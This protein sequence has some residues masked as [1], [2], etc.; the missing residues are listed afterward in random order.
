MNVGTASVFGAAL[1]GVADPE[2]ESGSDFDDV[3]VG[4]RSKKQLDFNPGDPVQTMTNISWSFHEELSPPDDL[5]THEDDDGF[6]HDELRIHPNIA[7]HFDKPMSSFL[8]MIPLDFW[9]N[10]LI[11]INCTATAMVERHN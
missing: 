4:L 11:Q 3:Q 5:Y 2:D 1:D 6:S 7:E 10:V 9:Q 8:G